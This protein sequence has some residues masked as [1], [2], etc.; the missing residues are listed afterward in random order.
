MSTGDLRRELGH[1][2][3]IYVKPPVLS[4]SCDRR[5]RTLSVITPNNQQRNRTSVFRN[6][7]HLK[8]STFGAKES[9]RVLVRM[10]DFYGINLCEMRISDKIS[11]ILLIDRS[12]SSRWRARFRSEWWG[13]VGSQKRFELLI[14]LLIASPSKFMNKKCSLHSKNYRI[15]CLRSAQRQSQRCKHQQIEWARLNQTQIGLG[16]PLASPPSRL[17][18]SDTFKRRVQLQETHHA[19]PIKY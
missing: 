3:I 18:A 19:R 16:A 1:K 12:S 15:A 14:F 4:H 13:G 8:S 9:S 7:F 17:C 6:T 11:I 2:C 10:L 5:V